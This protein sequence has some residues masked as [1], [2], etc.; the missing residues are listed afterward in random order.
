[1]ITFLITMLGVGAILVVLGIL[2]MMGNIS[3]L[4]SY[5]RHRVVKEDIK[6]FGRLVGLGT[7][8][9][10]VSIIVSGILIFLAE[11][12]DITALLAIGNILLAVLM[13]SGLGISIF[14]II[15]YN[16]GLF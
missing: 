14:A 2:N 6:P 12:L 10:G 8:L 3:S 15:K 11:L 4:H 7:V 5:H 9:C 1:M 13:I 16:K